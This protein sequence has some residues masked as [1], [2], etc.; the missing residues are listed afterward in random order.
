MVPLLFVQWLERT[1]TYLAQL[2]T[3][4]AALVSTISGSEAAKIILS[5]PREDAQDVVGFERAEGR[6]LGVTVGDTVSVVPTDT[7]E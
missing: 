2:S 4:E 5:S 6:R 1:K 3:Q 7:G